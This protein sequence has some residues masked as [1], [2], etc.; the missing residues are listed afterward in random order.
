MPSLKLTETA[1]ETAES[2]T[3]DYELRDKGKY[4]A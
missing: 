4:R 3:R 1:V 2:E